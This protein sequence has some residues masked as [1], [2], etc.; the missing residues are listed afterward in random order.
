MSWIVFWL[1]TQLW[2][3]KLSFARKVGVLYSLLQIGPKKEEN[4]SLSHQ[5]F[6]FW[7]DKTYSYASGV[8]VHKCLKMAESDIACRPSR[9]QNSFPNCQHP[10]PTLP[11]FAHQ[12]SNWMTYF[13]IALNHFGIKLG[14]RYYFWH[15]DLQSIS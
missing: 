7:H 9:L 3:A 12:Y 2:Q 1:V 14:H 15:V 10:P 4:M 13:G 6:V 5:Q 8:L 11:R